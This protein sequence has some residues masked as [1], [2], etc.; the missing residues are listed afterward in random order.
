MASGWRENRRGLLALWVR[1]GSVRRSCPCSRQELVRHS[2]KQLQ[3]RTRLG[4]L[5]RTSPYA[6]IVQRNGAPRSE[7][8]LGGSSARA[9]HWSHFQPWRH[10]ECQPQPGE[11]WKQQCDTWSNY[12]SPG[13]HVSPDFRSDHDAKW[14]SCWRWLFSHRLR[15]GTI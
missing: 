13:L 12:Y 3:W 14:R 2:A 8:Q 4:L 11:Q 9:E 1:H 5:Q 6:Q 10:A 7:R 15:H